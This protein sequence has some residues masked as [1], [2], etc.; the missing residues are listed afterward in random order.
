MS[1]NVTK[2]LSLGA[3]LAVLELRAGAGL[4]SPI[5]P[6]LQAGTDIPP[7][8]SQSEADRARYG[9][10]MSVPPVEGK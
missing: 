8:R 2:P 7:W 6:L 4:S 1:A 9:H 10:R 3:H 5:L